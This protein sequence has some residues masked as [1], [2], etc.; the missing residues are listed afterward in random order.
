MLLLPSRLEDFRQAAHS[1]S[2]LAIPR[3]VAVEPRRRRR[4]RPVGDIAAVRQARR[5]RPPGEPLVIVL[6]DPSQYRLARAISA[7][8]ERAEVWYLRADDVADGGEL[9]ELDQLARER[10]AETRS[11]ST[12][13]ALGEAEHALRLRLRELGVISHR[14]FVPGARVERR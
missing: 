8:Y 4:S 1:R 10:A 13:E 2:L 6:Y 9:S 5:L 3:V 12:P 11:I 7:R 14:P